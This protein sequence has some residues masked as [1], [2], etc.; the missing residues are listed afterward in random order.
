MSI[1]LRY[2]STP[3]SVQYFACCTRPATSFTSGIAS[4]PRG[5]A[6]ASEGTPAVMQH[7]LPRNAHHPSE[8]SGFSGFSVRV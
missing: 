8:T 6:W 1:L 7:Y 5:I 2:I 4:L 3:F